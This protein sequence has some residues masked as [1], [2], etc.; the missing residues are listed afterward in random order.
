MESGDDGVRLLL[1]KD[2]F[3][4]D[5]S[6]VIT[7]R[8]ETRQIKQRMHRVEVGKLIQHAAQPCLCVCL[9]PNPCMEMSGAVVLF[10]SSILSSMI[11]SFLED[12]CKV[13]TR[14]SES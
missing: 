7:K 14:Q 8:Y 13:N 12:T 10:T 11:D 2:S 5:C 9:R 6:Q 1:R 4:I 3:E